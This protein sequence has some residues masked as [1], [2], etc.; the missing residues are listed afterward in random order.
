MWWSSRMYMTMGRMRHGRKARHQRNGIRALDMQRTLRIRGGCVC[1][2]GAVDE[3]YFLER[4]ANGYEGRILQA[5]GGHGED[6]GVACCFI[7]WRG[8]GGVIGQGEEGLAIAS[9]D[10][11][12]RGGRLGE[13]LLFSRAEEG[14][15]RGR[16]S[17]A[18][19]ACMHHVT[20]WPYSRRCPSVKMK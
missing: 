17:R 2:H 10:D 7:A 20:Q 14:E 11:W 12:T 5:C 18:R 15:P 1:S 19:H 16:I 9:S 13:R 8:S 6:L 4:H 3:V